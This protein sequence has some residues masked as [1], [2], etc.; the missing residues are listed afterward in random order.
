VGELCDW[1][2]FANICSFISAKND[3]VSCHFPQ[4]EKL[5][6]P[7]GQERIIQY[8]RTTEERIPYLVRTQAELAYVT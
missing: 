8:I 2:T 3:F 4:Q 1:S 5:M 7:A 6:S